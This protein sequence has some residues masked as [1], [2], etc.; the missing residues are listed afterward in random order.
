VSQSGV[1]VRSQAAT[2]PDPAYDSAR[3]FEL[4]LLDVPTLPVSLIRQA[5]ALLHE[6][7]NPARCRD[8]PEARLP[9]SDQRPWFLELP[10]QIRVFLAMPHAVPARFN[11]QAGDAPDIWQDYLP[12]PF[13]WANSLLIHL[14]ALT[15]L[16]LPFEL[17]HLI[18]SV[19][20]PP[21][22]F[23]VTRIEFP[24]PQLHGNA[25]KTGGGG[26]G[27]DRSPLPA[28]RGALPQFART[29]FTPPRVEIPK[30]APAL[31]MQATL[32]GP[33]ELK[34]PAMKLDMPFGDPNNPPGPPSQGQGTGGGIGDGNGTG[35]GPGT[36]PGTGPGSD[37]GYGGDAFQ[38]GGVHGASAPIP[39]YSPEPAYSEEAR[40]AKFSGIVTM[41]VVVDALGN[42]RN[43]RVI[44]PLGMGLDE[45]ALKTVATWRFK[46][47]IRH[48]V[49]VPVQVLVEVSFRLF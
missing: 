32:L 44:K 28:S 35:V 23:D 46:P 14:F 17:Q 12:N 3:S 18:K 10:A 24:L 1:D 5:N 22:I 15:L 47:A 38:V 16:V 6:R 8:Q 2:I 30:V 41:W 39:I 7:R 19:P 49:A 25:D 48:N 34:L 27:G 20:A 26:G 11:S 42:V 21:K 45:E 37:G 4:T 31:P 9:L 33:P 29:Q 13:S 43:P 40:K 36:G